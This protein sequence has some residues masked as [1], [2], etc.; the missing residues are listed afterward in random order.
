MQ[1][2]I[3]HRGVDAHQGVAVS[4]EQIMADD[5][6]PVPL[7]KVL[8]QHGAV[9]EIYEDGRVTGF[10]AEVT[11]INYA[12]QLLAFLRQRPGAANEEGAPDT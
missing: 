5:S 9:W 1:I 4:M 8:G 10:P 2:V 3:E 6:G 12:R 7:F 11:V